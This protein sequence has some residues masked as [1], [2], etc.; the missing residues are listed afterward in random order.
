VDPGS[1]RPPSSDPGPPH[2]GPPAAP[3]GDPPGA[4][5]TF[6]WLSGVD[7]AFLIH[8][9]ERTG[10]TLDEYAVT[11]HYER[12][13]T[14][15]AL[16]AG[17]GVR[18]VRYGLPWHRINPARGHWDFTFA[19]RALAALLAHGLRPVVQL[20]HHGVPE[21]IHGG[22][23]NPQFAE[24]LAEYAARV[25]ERFAGRIRAYT[26]VCDPRTTAW[27]AGRLGAMPPA[28]RTWRGFV[29]VLLGACRAIARTAARLRAID[30]GIALVHVETAELYGAADPA[31]ETEMRHRE[32]L[33]FLALDLVTGRV[34]PKHPLYGWLLAFGAT[35]AQL[36]GFWDHVHEPDLVGLVVTPAARKALTRG[37]GG[38]RVRTPPTDATVVSALAERYW[39]RY[40]RPVFVAGTGAGG[41]V[42]RR[43]AWL[44]ASIAA[45][46]RTR[47]GGIPL[48]GYGWWP[49]YGPV[50]WSYRDGDGTPA[51]YLEPTG[52]YD[53]EARGSGFEP[54][55]TSLVGRYRELVRG[56]ADA[57]GPLAARDAA[58]PNAPGEPRPA[59]GG[60]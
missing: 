9:S 40:G 19:D 58:G 48:V 46:A 2:A 45:V 31:L 49:L 12:L 1:T 47:A 4:P 14:D 16:L 11:G 56:G 28:Q 21:W 43:R 8:P 38:L 44:E 37:P 52:L 7:D 3:F 41:P 42:E 27:H 53:L 26:P 32:A 30:P 24:F 23:A 54:V 18:T 55:P 25:A 20:V 5:T 15:V 36:G 34:R 33:S 13:E 59:S 60:D 51:D 6:E 39:T 17:V 22:C 57:V 50:A 35:P 10:R 29:T